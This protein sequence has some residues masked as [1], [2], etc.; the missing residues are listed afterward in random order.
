LPVA[1]APQSEIMTARVN[2]IMA[3]AKLEADVNASATLPRPMAVP[4]KK[5]SKARRDKRRAQHKIESP[6]LNLC[7]QCGQ[8]K[9]PHRVCP[10]CHTYRGRDIDPLRT[11]AP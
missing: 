1:A 11:P 7:P 10:T 8:P 2:V 9:R 5:T 6:R 3:P 4:K